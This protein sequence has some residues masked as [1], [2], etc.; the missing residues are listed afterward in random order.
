MLAVT[1]ALDVK[2]LDLRAA[3]TR[4][5]QAPSDEPLELYNVAHL[6]G[7][8]AG[9]KN[10]EYVIVGDAGD[11]L[12]VLNDGAQIRVLGNVG[13]Y[14]GDNMTRGLIQIEGNAAYGAG[15]YPYGG[16]LVVR[17]DAGDFTA[18]MNKGATIIVCGNVGDEC[19]TY[20][21][22]GDFIVVGNAG[23]N[24]GNYL[25]RGALYIGGE[26]ESQGHNTRVEE[27]TQDDVL[28]LMH[29]FEQFDIAA[30]PYR[31]KKF[32]AKSQKPFYE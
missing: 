17:G 23:L 18:T 19:A 12:G 27:V 29:Y 11:Y 13:S 25:I 5:K 22:A 24:F 14:V 32:T 2:D 20:H 31:F 28:K 16:T 8:L 3:S 4:V 10:G 7:F 26:F 1:T 6:H 30:D 15:L 9:L 21:L